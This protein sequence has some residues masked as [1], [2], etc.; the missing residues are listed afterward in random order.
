MS[1]PNPDNP[2]A[3]FTLTFDGDDGEATNVG[4]TLEF[5]F[6]ENAEDF[7]DPAEFTNVAAGVILREM[8]QV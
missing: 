1:E 2:T 6:T 8:L 7:I 3:Q 5:H 4:I